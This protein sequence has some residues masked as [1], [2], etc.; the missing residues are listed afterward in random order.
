[1]YL[2]LSQLL[3]SRT[4]VGMSIARVK[5]DI[6]APSVTDWGRTPSK[7]RYVACAALLFRHIEASK[8][9]GMNTHVTTV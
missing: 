1:M 6:F 5:M 4:F 9:E 3:R 2:G 7:E 8:A